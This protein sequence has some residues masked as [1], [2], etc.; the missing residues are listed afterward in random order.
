MYF[1]KSAIFLIILI[2]LQACSYRSSEFFEDIIADNET[3]KADGQFK[4]AVEKSFDTPILNNEKSIEEDELLKPII[5]RGKIAS[6]NFD[7]DYNL[8]VY[9]FIDEVTNKPITF[10]Y[11]KNIQYSKNKSFKIEVKGNYLH[12]ITTIHE[13]NSSKNSDALS[14][15]PQ[16]SSYKT[17]PRKRRRS[18]IRTPI[19]EKINTL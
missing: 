11:D 2:F 8:Y 9:T 12:K 1:I 18:F 13:N 6:V 16:K 15:Q 7:K 5:S 3:I 17:K 14:S 19:E 4:K 10:Y